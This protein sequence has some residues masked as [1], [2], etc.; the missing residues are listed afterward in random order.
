LRPYLANVPF[1]APVVPLV[2]N[3][4]VA[5]LSEPAAIKDAL[6]RQAASPVRW[7]ESVQK[8][9]GEGVTHVIECGPGKALAGM[10][11]RING[12]LVGDAIVDQASLDKVLE[13]LK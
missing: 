1:A 10:V 3:V 2:N 4:D 7:V 11:K 13:L 6:V 9:A 12:D 5:V 8:M